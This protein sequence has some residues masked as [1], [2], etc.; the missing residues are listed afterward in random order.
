MNLMLSKNSF[1]QLL[2]LPQSGYTHRP[3]LKSIFSW[4]CGENAGSH[5]LSLLDPAD[6]ESL[7][8]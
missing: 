4:L 8:A 3:P 2:I 6:D 7:V 5:N 1:C